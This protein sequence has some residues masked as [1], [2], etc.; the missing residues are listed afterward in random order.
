MAPS[1]KDAAATSNTQELIVAVDVAA[2]IPASHRACPTTNPPIPATH[3]A[4]L[5]S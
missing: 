5:K 2:M 3:I 1:T 4:A